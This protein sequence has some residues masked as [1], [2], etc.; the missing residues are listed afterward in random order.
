MITSS[1]ATGFNHTAAN[2]AAVQLPS[3]RSDA[4]LL[5]R[6]EDV[7]SLRANG[8]AG[9]ESV[10]TNQPAPL[11]SG[12]AMVRDASA[13]T[14]LRA[15]NQAA[16]PEFSTALQQTAV[17]NSHTGDARVGTET[18]TVALL[19]ETSSQPPRVSQFVGSEGMHAGASRT[20]LQFDA[21][22][23]T[24]SSFPLLSD[25]ANL[26]YEGG[27]I[28]ATRAT[29]R[30][31]AYASASNLS[32]AAS[33]H[34]GSESLRTGVL[35]TGV[36]AQGTFSLPSTA[37]TLVHKGGEGVSIGAARSVA[38]ADD[39]GN[40]S[41]SAQPAPISQYVGKEG[42]RVG[43]AR[44]VAQ[45]DN[46][47]RFS[48][49]GQPAPVSQ[50]G[51]GNEGERIGTARLVAQA[52]DSG[53]FSAATQLAAISQYVGNESAS[54]GV[55]RLAAQASDSGNFSSSSDLRGVSQFVGN[56]SASIGSTRLVAQAG[57]EA[58]S[59]PGFVTQYARDA[60]A[61]V[62]RAE[63]LQN[64]FADAAMIPVVATDSMHTETQMV[65]GRVSNSKVFSWT[66][67]S[68][69]AEAMPMFTQDPD[70]GDAMH[71]QD[72]YTSHE[73][74]IRET[75]AQT[76]IGASAAGFRNEY[77]TT[78]RRKDERDVWKG[79]KGGPSAQIINA[80]LEN[81]LYQFSTRPQQ[82]EDMEAT[83][84]AYESDVG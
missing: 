18:R 33:Q 55:A 63:I 24:S 39:S 35:R 56:E 77:E 65:P 13:G 58:F 26:G 59:G 28:G 46:S 1:H 62:Q 83:R 2:A 5:Q 10:S 69:V 67:Q 47:G 29:T 72:K 7:G 40:F 80:L 73:R 8:H 12:T 37:N 32:A 31:D 57:S 14:A 43:T 68:I 78:G 20:S 54:I 48:S 61:G 79:R 3:A 15:G 64:T 52:D 30:P 11:P 34:A 4:T 81:Q 27:S 25:S 60:R 75:L 70:K 16:T 74:V 17:L 42:V 50:Y 9:V 19:P 21:N 66:G 23:K 22:G 53:N 44:L 6:S 51:G 71:S 84:I 36:Q 45:A 76:A 38:Q 82:S 41:S 49:S